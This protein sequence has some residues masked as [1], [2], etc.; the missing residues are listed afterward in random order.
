MSIQ[1][2]VENNV[3]IW[4][5]QPTQESFAGQLA[6]IWEHRKVFTA[7]VRQVIAKMAE[8][9]VLGL[10]LMLFQPI[11]LAAPAVFMLKMF[12]LSGAPIPIAMFVVPGLAVAILVRRGVPLVARSLSMHRGLMRRV[13]IPAFLLLGAS[14]SPAIVQFLVFMGIFALLA[15]FYGPI[16]GT[17]YISFG[18]HLLAVAPA[19]LL[20]FLLIMAVGCFTCVLVNIRRDTG[21]V[22]KY[23]LS[24]WMLI[25]PA[26]YP[27]ELIPESN[28]WLLYLNPLTPPLEVFRFGLFG[29]GTVHTPSLC[30]AVAVTFFMLLI[31]GAI[32]FRLQNRLFDHV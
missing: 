24:G 21:L 20:V 13:Y 18:W 9:K 8:R 16:T 29:Y 17:F 14:L 25:T 1:D 22:V 12:N 19:I 15:I 5:I 31:G 7:L 6:A 10:P 32:F 23:V 30:L 28:R 27:P 3:A 2:N 11:M 26:L 4:R